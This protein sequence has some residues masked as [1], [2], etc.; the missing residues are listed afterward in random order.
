[1]RRVTRNLVFALLVIVALLLALG[2]LPSYLK[3]GDPY[4]LTVTPVATNHT[5][6]NVSDLPA[7]RYPYTTTALAN[8][9]TNESGRSDPYWKGPVGFK[10]AFTHSPFDEY[11]ALAQQHPDA[12][13]GETVYVRQ[14]NTVYHLTVTQQP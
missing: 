12:V 13:D 11:E 2:A 6:A 10:G 5:A 14:N 9:S 8:A 1:M 7:D 3:S 4:Y